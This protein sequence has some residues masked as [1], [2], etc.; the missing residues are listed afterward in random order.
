MTGVPVHVAEN[1]FARL[2]A[3]GHRLVVVEPEGAA[4]AL[5]AAVAVAA[6]EAEPS[7][8]FLAIPKSAITGHGVPV[9]LALF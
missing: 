8:L 3:Q 9:Q 2:L 1:Y 7:R 6:D 5:T 4:R